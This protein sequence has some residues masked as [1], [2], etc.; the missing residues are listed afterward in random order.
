MLD[1]SALLQTTRF[2][3]TCVY[4]ACY[5]VDVIGQIANNN[6]TGFGWQGEIRGHCCASTCPPYYDSI[7]VPVHPRLRKNLVL[8]PDI[9]MAV[10]GRAPTT[11]HCV[12]LGI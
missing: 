8:R 10:L 2:C 5:N 7:C 12:L 9:Y 3:R 1:V 11:M 4:M 6:N